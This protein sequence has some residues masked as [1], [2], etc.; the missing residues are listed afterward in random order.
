MELCTRYFGTINYNNQNVIS[1]EN[2]IP[3]FEDLRKFTLIDVENVDNL[4]CL[5]S[6]EDGNICLFMVPPA[7]LVDNYDI[8][9]NDKI[10]DELEL[11]SQEEAELYTLL[12]I[13]DNMRETTANLRCPIIINTTTNKGLQGVLENTTYEIREKIYK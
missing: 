12:N 6:L 3:G 10:V 8:D 7:T 1:F 11:K 4:T 2:G 5:Q 9:V 13:K